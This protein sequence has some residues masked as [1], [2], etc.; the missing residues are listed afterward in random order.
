MPKIPNVVLA[1]FIAVLLMIAVFP[2]VF[3]LGASLCHSSLWYGF[4]H[5]FRPIVL[6]GEP[7]NRQWCHAYYDNAGALWQ[8]EPM[9][10]FMKAVIAKGESPYWNPYS[11]CGQLGPETLVDLKFSFQT[12][13]MALTGGND[14]AFHVIVLISYA[15]STFLLFLLLSRYFKLSSLAAT[16]ACIGYLLNGYNVTNLCT[17]TSQVYLYFPLGLF[18]L[19]AFAR[20]PS[21]ARY[22]FLVLANIII[23]S[24]TFLPTCF[25]LLLG[26]YGISVGYIL[27]LRIR[28]KRSLSNYVLTV[29]LMQFSAAFLALSSLSYLYLPIVESF[30]VVDPISMYNARV[31][32]PANLNSLLSFFSPR[33][34]WDEYSQLSEFASP[35]PQHP[36]LWLTNV[37]F[38][39]G[40][41]PSVI[42][43]SVLCLKLG[44]RTPIVVATLAVLA[45]SLGRIFNVPLIST[46]IG[47]LPGLKSIGEQ[48]WFIA[49][50]I[51]FPLLV[52]F[53]FDALRRRSKLR[54]LPILLVFG[55]V[56]SSLIH[57]YANYG[58]NIPF[59]GYTRNSVIFLVLL[60][61]LSAVLIYFVQQQR[62]PS[63]QIC[64]GLL[65]LLIFVELTHDMIHFRYT[66][67]DFFT[68]PPPEIQFLKDHA[69]YFRVANLSKG[70]LPA[71]LGSAFQ[72]QQIES[73]NMNVLPTYEKFFQH[74][75]LNEQK[76]RWGPFPTLCRHIDK[77]MINKTALDLLAVKY[78]CLPTIWPR[79]T[80][81]LIAHH[82][83]PVF[84]TASIRIFENQKVYPRIFAVPTLLREEKTPDQHGLSP[85]V[86][87]FSK[88]EK[89]LS[90]ANQLGVCDNKSKPLASGIP[91]SSVH[92]HQYR[93]AEVIATAN[94]TTPAVIVLMDNWHPN[95][96]AFAN[97][98]PVY[99]GRINESFRGIALPAGRHAIKMRYM[100]TTLPIA[101]SI[102]YI[103]I[104]FLT[105]LYLLRSRID[106]LFRHTWSPRYVTNSQ[107]TKAGSSQTVGS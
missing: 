22:L 82:C 105:I 101:Q 41:V 21:I 27:S 67:N 8:S 95:W 97:E 74:N 3:F 58:I 38:H 80:A 26:I 16:A 77:P 45:A 93:H 6:F 98:K 34:F 17:N 107:V 91:E 51:A 14:I 35:S 96:H 30:K 78:I 46:I 73:L 84:R 52:G 29:V 23:L 94:L 87:A 32:Y 37:M 9:Q 44:W 47:L 48:Y 61:P 7:R 4:E 86:V 43:A 65:L 25:L 60:M 31:F 85:R 89:L 70:A 79:Y 40:V 83:R 66:R 64:C 68:K 63:S 92:L 24:T 5:G 88:D 54:W 90:I 57:I 2:D 72:I 42:V 18:A 106:S 102:S 33:H 56:I 103:T 71:E 55:V 104:M 100:P 11:G 53:G 69:G 62:K 75:F 49:V 28:L 59:K 81:Y 1:A 99:I 50:A 76:Y 15:V 36:N 20:N 19:C 13:L 39:F 10:Q 12:L